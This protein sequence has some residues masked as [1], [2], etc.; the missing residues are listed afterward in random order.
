MSNFLD[1]LACDAKETI[2]SGYYQTSE[3]STQPQISLRKAILDCKFT[4]V[5]TEIKSASPS[6]GKIR[7]KIN[8]EEIS[9]TMERAGAVGISILTE[10]KHF[11]GSLLTLAHARKAVKLPI[12]MKDIIIDPAQIEVAAKIGANSVLLIEYLFEKGYCEI[13]LDEMINFA[14]SKGLEVLLEAHTD[15]EFHSAIATNADLVGIN[16]RNLGTLKIDLDTTRKILENHTNHEKLVI[17]ESGIRTQSDL[18][19]LRK[20]GASAFLIGSSIMLAEN[21]EEKIKEFVEA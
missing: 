14:H 2:K 5:I 1:V 18:Q 15:E 6:L 21:F 9:Q 11:N 13:S 16:N 4:P 20:C 12:L 8:P 10:P 19:F 7:D 3:E 17:S